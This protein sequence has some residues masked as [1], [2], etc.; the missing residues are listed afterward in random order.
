M[1]RASRALV[2]LAL[3]AAATGAAAS[4]ALSDPSVIVTRWSPT[5]S[6]NEGTAPNGPTSVTISLS[7][8]DGTGE[9]R[10][11]AS[12]AATVAGEGSWSATLVP[13]ATAPPA[14]SHAPALPGDQLDVQYTGAS[15]P[16]DQAVGPGLFYDILDSAT[17]SADGSHADYVSSTGDCSTVTF[18]ANG[19]LV[20]TTLHPAATPS[21]V[22]TCR[23]DFFPPLSSDDSLQVRDAGIMF[24]AP[25]VEGVE[26]VGL[27]GAA[28]GD[29]Q[30]AGPPTCDAD[31]VD[32]TV[33][34]SHLN[35]GAFEVARNGGAP[36][37]LSYRAGGDGTVA[38]TGIAG[39]TAG[40]VLVLR[41]QGHARALT[42]L[43][44][45]PL[46]VDQT[47]DLGPLG[48]TT[49]TAGEC[50][51]DAWLD[52]GSQLCAADGTPA[53]PSA[54]LGE[55]I[56]SSYDDLSGGTTT[57]DHGEIA[58][59]IPADGAAVGGSF[60][61]FL[62]VTGPPP[63]SILL[64]L[65]H[66]AADGGDGALAAGPMPVEPGAGA[67]VSGLTLGRYNA[68]WS[69]SDSHADTRSLATQFVVQPGG[70]GSAG[71]PGPSGPS[72]PAG[73]AGAGGTAG[74]AGTR[75]LNGERGPAGPRGA[76]GVGVQGVACRARLKHRKV[77]VVC[78]VATSARF[79]GRIAL[80]V[81]RGGRV[82][83]RGARHAGGRSLTV[84]AGPIGAAAGRRCEA[85]L[86]LV[87]RGARRGVRLHVVV[88]LASP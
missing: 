71:P 82:L 88:R 30:G 45:D 17:L 85:L 21:D 3:V 79:N 10:V 56:A 78:R 58:S 19:S 57:L 47:V 39:L 28:A 43:T 54:P 24:D 9:R 26:D 50:A 6:G 80:A 59:A 75:G 41:E 87:P 61:A 2:C 55:D 16:P 23:A 15:V 63:A 32:A 27:P 36:A 73:P 72:G 31:L 22:D 74:A 53:T 4:P 49:T 69:V 14:R 37:Q 62:D 83:A 13:E 77:K 34:C 18:D 20:P 65:M 40:D 44:I 8:I 42:T 7:R 1:N 51:P 86:S 25:E 48:S 64:M 11:V 84:S 76:P 68:H 60:T 67:S 5:V 29:G 35:G 70:E 81:K 33:T 46:R 52:G 12:G 38:A 66:R